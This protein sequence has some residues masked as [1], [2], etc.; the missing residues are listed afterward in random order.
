MVSRVVFF[1][2]MGLTGC[3]CTAF[4]KNVCFGVAVLVIRSP[5]LEGFS[6]TKTSTYRAA[7]TAT[8]MM[9]PTLKGESKGNMASR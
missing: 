2:V 1:G 5:W 6:L 3:L 4:L 8:V 7:R 9:K